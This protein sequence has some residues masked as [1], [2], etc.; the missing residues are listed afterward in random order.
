M[1]LPLKRELGHGREPRR[2][3][4]MAWYE[5]R[6]RVGVYFPAPLHLLARGLREFR[7]RVVLAWRAPTREQR[8]VL[9]LQRVHREREKLAAEYSRGYL[10]G[11]QECFEQWVETIEL[12]TVDDLKH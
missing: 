3:W 2:G 5:P 4:R 12:V 11:W 9:D 8:D 1:N 7:Y 10:C 6:R